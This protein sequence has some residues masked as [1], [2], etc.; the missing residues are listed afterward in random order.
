M[1][2]SFRDS[3]VVSFARDGER[4][5]L[6][7]GPDDSVLHL[8]GS[9]GLGLAPVEV[10]R[11]DRAGGHGSVVRNVRLEDREVFI[12][13]HLSADSAGGLTRLRRELTELLDPL[14]GDV[15][16]W[17]EDP[18]LES[19]R[20]VRGYLTEGLDGDFGDA[21]YG[22]WQNLGLTFLC[23]DPWWYGAE[24]VREWSLSTINKPYWSRFPR[25]PHYPAWLSSS[26][27]LGDFEFT[28][29]GD[30]AASPVW[31]VFPPGEDLLIE[32]GNGCGKRLFLEGEITEPVTFDVEN[33]DISSPSLDRGE[34]WE[35][36]S[37]DSDF[38][39][40]GPGENRVRVSMVGAS[41]AA[42]VRLAYR[43]KFKVAI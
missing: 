33:G 37:L 34:L 8:Y 40:L 28:V 10:S 20:M 39:D 35:R 12:P 43:E 1:V 23:P 26:T 17:V 18:V 9:T 14:R 15:E 31:T 7:R 21:F 24:R 3:P 30:A 19:R 4:F 16:V 5:E 32:C 2:S 27:V 38:F 11:T 22:S 6:G 36:V 13:V 41:G 42:R 29:S 25:L